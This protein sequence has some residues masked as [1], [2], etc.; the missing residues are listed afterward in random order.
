METAGALVSGRNQRV[1]YLLQVHILPAAISPH[2]M[3][4]VTRFSLCK[5]LYHGF[6]RPCFRRI[7]FLKLEGCQLLVQD[8]RGG[9][10]R[11]PA[12]QEDVSRT[13][14][15]LLSFMIIA[16]SRGLFKLCSSMWCVLCGRGQ[17]NK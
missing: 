2:G 10:W 3:N 5:R 14:M 15:L 13:P 7:R 12:G 1:L 9:E 16:R 8:G 4:A 11:D 6:S 17:K